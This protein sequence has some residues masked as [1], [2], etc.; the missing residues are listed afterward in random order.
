MSAYISKLGYYSLM[1]GIVGEIADRFAKHLSHRDYNLGNIERFW[2]SN[3]T[4]LLMAAII[5]V[6][7]MVFRKGI[8]LQNETDLTV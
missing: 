7:A 3:G 8:E 6:I 4:Y 2:D 5:F 1:I